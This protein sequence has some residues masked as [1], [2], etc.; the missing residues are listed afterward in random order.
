LL[1]FEKIK[2]TPEIFPRRVGKAL[3]KPIG[4]YPEKV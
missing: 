1:V 4:I 3:K 2:E